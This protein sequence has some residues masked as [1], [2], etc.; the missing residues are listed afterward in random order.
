[1]TGIVKV[2]AGIVVRDGR[3]LLG[4]RKPDKDHPFLW[5]CPGGKVELGETD[6]QALTREL[7][8]E[9]DLVAVDFLLHPVWTGEFKGNVSRT[10]RS[11][12]SLSF[13]RVKTCVGAVIPREGHGWGWFTQAEFVAMRLVNAL[14]PANMRA[15]DEVCAAAFQSGAPSLPAAPTDSR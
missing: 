4:Q 1:M 2:V 12:I 11:H 8:E 5:E 3:L 7:R 15:F 9:F 10:D 14:A 13:Y 6:Y